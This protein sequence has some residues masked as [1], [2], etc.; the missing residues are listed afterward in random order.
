MPG[1]MTN[2]G[3]PET[4]PDPQTGEELEEAIDTFAAITED[5]NYKHAKDALGE[6]V[7]ALDLTPE[8]RAG[9]EPEI[10]GLQTMLEKLE[11]AVVQ[12]AVFGMVGRGKSSLLNALLGDNAFVTG[13]IHGVTRNIQGAAWKLTP[14]SESGKEIGAARRRDGRFTRKSGTIG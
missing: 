7:A 1:Q 10:G 12:I 4:T 13:P 2:E 11:Q 5:L 8:E 9:L 14:T 3:I 6:L